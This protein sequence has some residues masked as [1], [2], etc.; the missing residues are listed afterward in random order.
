[1]ALRTT[2]AEVASD[3]LSAADGDGETDREATD[4]DGDKVCVTTGVP[5]LPS[6]VADAQ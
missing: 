5:L 3:A 2:D 1:M 4:A 6:R